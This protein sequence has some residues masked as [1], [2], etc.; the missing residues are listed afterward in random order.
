M[1][2]MKFALF[3]LIPISLFGLAAFLIYARAP[4]W[5]WFLLCVT[6][7]CGGLHYETKSEP[8]AAD[9]GQH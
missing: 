5:G 9:V 7:V 8:D 3:C 1:T 4:G 6:L 2:D